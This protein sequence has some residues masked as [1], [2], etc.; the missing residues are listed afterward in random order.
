MD[1]MEQVERCR[2]RLRQEQRLHP[3]NLDRS[4]QGLLLELLDQQVLQLAGQ[5]LVQDRLGQAPAHLEP[6]LALEA[7]ASLDLQ[8]L[9]D[10]QASPEQLDLA[11]YPS[12]NLEVPTL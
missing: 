11:W 8:A 2:L 10:R 6:E 3:K 7:P 1:R 12:Q 4:N 5:V 9:E